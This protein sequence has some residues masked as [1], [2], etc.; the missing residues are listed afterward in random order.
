MR[1][2]TA[3][4]KAGGLI[5]A[6]DM[7][8]VTQAT[9]LG[10][11]L[12]TLDQKTFVKQPGNLSKNFPNLKIAQESRMG[13][14]SGKP[15][16]YRVGRKLM[17]LGDIIID[18][19]GR[20]T[21]PPPDYG[22]GGV[23]ASWRRTS[24]RPRCGRSRPGAECRPRGGGGGVGVDLPGRSDDRQ[25]EDRRQNREDIKKDLTRLGPAIAK[26]REIDPTQG[27]LLIFNFQAGAEVPIGSVKPAARY[28]FVE[29]YYGHTEQE[30]RQT[31][32]ATAKQS[33]IVTTSSW[34][35]PLVPPGVEHP[36]DAVPTI[37]DRHVHAGS[38]GAPGRQLRLHG[39]RRRGDH[40]AR[41]AGRDDTPVHHP[42]P[43]E[44]GE[45]S[46]PVLGWRNPTAHHLAEDGG[47]KCD[48]PDR[49]PR[50]CPVVVL[51]RRGGRDGLP[52]RRRDPG[53]VRRHVHDDELE[54][55]SRR[56]T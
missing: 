14:I 46:R 26:N 41:R 45:V 16:D 6:E 28:L 47:G 12:W 30:A 22:G 7:R 35:P 4:A 17:G 40:P 8:L 53:P 15:N 9:Q 25:P 11:E 36:E 3:N 54:H 43:T 13:V 19:Q 27:V 5:S 52:G 21:E 31:I 34:V 38:G 51:L 20:I 55:D 24:A 48:D 1:Q 18:F 33:G 39:V 32:P 10:A 49:Q 23:A 50:P 29:D 56:R 2:L 37:R 42:G 44:E